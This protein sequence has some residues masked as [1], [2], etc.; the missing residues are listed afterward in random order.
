MQKKFLFV[1]GCPRSG[2]TYFHSLLAVHPAIALGLER[3]NLRMFSRNL[4]PTDFER[5]RFFRMEAGD[6]WYA[7]LAHFPRKQALIEAHYDTADYVGDKVPRAYEV[8]DHL[9]THFPDVCFICVVR[10]VFDVAASYETR[11]RDVTHWN[12]D[13]GPRKAVEHWNA[14][15][16]AILAYADAAPILPVV[17]EDIVASEASLIGVSAFLG[18]DPEPLQTAWR[19]TRLKNRPEPGA[20][21]ARLSAEDVAYITAAADHDALARVLQLAHR[22]VADRDPRQIPGPSSG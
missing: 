6:T 17:Y 12:P 20:G 10:N 8:F 7:D 13:W 3:F 1:C 22:P 15:L 9:I 18:I 2:T 4:M 5:E 21:A 11:R 14:S 19:K 16:K